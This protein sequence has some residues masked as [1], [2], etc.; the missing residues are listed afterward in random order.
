MLSNDHTIFDQKPFKQANGKITLTF[1]EIAQS[2]EVLETVLF[3]GIKRLMDS[4]RDSEKDPAKDVYTEQ[5]R[6]AEQIRAGEL[7]SRGGGGSISAEE[8]ARR[9]ILAGYAMQQLGMPRQDAEKHARDGTS[10]PYWIGLRLYRQRYDAEPSEDEA[11]HAASKVQER[12]A[13]LV[14]ERLQAQQADIDV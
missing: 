9:D 6:R 3:H 1:G 13:Q 10:I 7:W 4:I 5:C 8:Y 2:D 11:N 14:S 12:V